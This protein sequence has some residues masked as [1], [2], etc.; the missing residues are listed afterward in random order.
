M[1]KRASHRFLDFSLADSSGDALS[2]PQA[3][4]DRFTHPQN[5][6]GRKRKDVNDL[7]VGT[8]KGESSSFKAVQNVITPRA[9]PR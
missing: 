6:Q 3:E 4:Q 8:G 7:D 9:V 1:K 5:D 2:A